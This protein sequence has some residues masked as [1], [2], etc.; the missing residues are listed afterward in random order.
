[1]LFR[2]VIPAKRVQAPGLDVV[3]DGNAAITGRFVVVEDYLFVKIGKHQLEKYETALVTA[4][5]RASK[6]GRESWR[7][8]V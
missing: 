6:I 4:S 5:T 7:E 3:I 2:S 8:S 1:M